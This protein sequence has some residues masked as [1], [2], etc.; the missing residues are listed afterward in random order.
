MEYPDDLIFLPSIRF[1]ECRCVAEL[2]GFDF[3]VPHF[4]IPYSSGAW[5]EAL[6]GEI[7]PFSIG[8]LS[9]FAEF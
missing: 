8:D 2:M 6:R 4:V 5:V 3:D 9:F 1:C 7:S